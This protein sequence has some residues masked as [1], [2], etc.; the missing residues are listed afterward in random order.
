MKKHIKRVITHPLFSG[1]L[2][3]I[4]G[5]NSANAIN[6]LYHLIIGRLLGPSLYGE[7][8]SLISAIA[9]LGIIP[10]ALTLVIIKE[11]SSTSD[12]TYVGNL[13]AY[14]KRNIFLASLIFS[15]LILL[16]SK[17]ILSFLHIY[18]LSYLIIIALLFLFSQ[19]SLLNRSILQGLLKFKEYVLSL[20]FENVAKLILSIVLIYIGLQVFGAMTAFLLSVFLG[21][22]LTNYLSKVDPVKITQDPTRIKPMLIFAIPVI[23]QTIALTSLYTTDVILVKHFFSSHDAGIYASL[24]TLGKIIFF[25]TGPISAVMFPM[26][27]QRKA[28]GEDFKRVF[29]YS[30]LITGIFSIGA[31][32]IYGLFPKLV[33]GLLFGSA[34]LEAENILVWFGLFIT[35]F[36]LSSLIVTYNLSLSR[37]RVTIFPLVAAILQVFLIILFH[38]T[39]FSVIL[40]STSITA[41]LLISLL[42]YSSYDARVSQ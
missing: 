40:I 31:V 38:K 8:A 27:S 42:I 32:M 23:L 5:S 2:I 20:L 14:L 13:I 1:S 10:S 6:Y 7:L 30:L 29:T 33:I 41:L 28:K 21:F 35:L 22:Y 17:F 34:Y 25:A 9:L 36:S 24:S 18:N 3:M 37:I 15:I 11:I 39:L 19:Q 4:I 26:I 16:F 12:K